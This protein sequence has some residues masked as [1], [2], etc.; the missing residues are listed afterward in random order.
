MPREGAVLD[1]SD[2]S[3][4]QKIMHDYHVHSHFSCDSEASMDA[5]CQAAINSGIHELG[6]S[7]HFDLH[8][9]EPFRDYLDLESW[10][11]SFEAC[12]VKFSDALVLRAGVEVGEPH[13]FPQQVERLLQEYP[14]DFI[15]G[16]LHWVGDSCV[17]DRAFFQNDE[18]SAYL[19]YFRELEHLVDDGLFDVL[20]HFDVVKRYGYE[21][22]GEF[23]PEQYE[24]QIRRILHKLA[25]RSL[26]IEIN[27]STLRR[28]IQM[29]SPDSRILQWFLEDGG[30]LVTLGSDAHIPQDVGFGLEPMQTMVR[31][32]GYRG[33]VQYENRQGVIVD[34]GEYGN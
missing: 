5:M 12:K 19:A 16:S 28:S 3:I 30:R 1:L 11:H 25:E 31:S 2:H 6:F 7:D 20:A 33:L 27:T 14:W 34:F 29:P 10:W 26:A 23:Q 22:Y 9:N 17:F 32:V 13:R 4:P 15:L 24:D 8:P 21:H 18:H